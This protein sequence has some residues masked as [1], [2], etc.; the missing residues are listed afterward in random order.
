MSKRFIYL[1]VM[2]V[3]LSAVA[4]GPIQVMSK[5]NPTGIIIE[6]GCTANNGNIELE[7]KIPPGDFGAGWA[8]YSI[9]KFT[10]IDG[11]G[12]TQHMDIPQKLFPLGPNSNPRKIVVQNVGAVFCLKAK[13]KLP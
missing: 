13:I 5:N 2:M 8:K 9:G 10:Y 11:Q 4:D 7:N 3:S 6:D 1:I 12:L